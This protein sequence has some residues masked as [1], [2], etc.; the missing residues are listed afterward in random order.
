MI[1]AVGTIPPTAIRT[2]ART[3]PSAPSSAATTSVAI[4]GKATGC[5]LSVDS[6]TIAPAVPQRW[7]TIA[8]RPRASRQTIVVFSRGPSVA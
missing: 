5:Q 4:A 2:S 6:A 1:S 3:L 8:S 7:C